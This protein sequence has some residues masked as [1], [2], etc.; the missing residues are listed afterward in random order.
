MFQSTKIADLQQ[1]VASLE[2]SL[3]TAT[4]ERDTA[5]AELTTLRTQAAEATAAHESA[6]AALNDSHKAALEAAEKEAES[7]AQLAVADALAAQ[8]VPAERLP[9]R[10]A[11][12]SST[13][14]T[15][16][17]EDLN[18]QISATKDPKQKGILA[19]QILDIMDAQAKAKANPSSRN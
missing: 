6:L 19:A 5:A 17:I 7:R 14:D 16:K 10:A 12:A 3:A 15:A 9:S 1:R 11:T 13:D 8:G 2:E 18:A 4:A